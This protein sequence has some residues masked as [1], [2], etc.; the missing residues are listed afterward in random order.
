MATALCC[1]HHQYI[2][3]NAKGDEKVTRH[4]HRSIMPSE[5]AYNTWLGHTLTYID[6]PKAGTAG[7][8]YESDLTTNVAT[9]YA[10]LRLRCS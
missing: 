9:V 3:L 6:A 5:W 1:F 2:Y 10:W 4:V 7:H 8:S